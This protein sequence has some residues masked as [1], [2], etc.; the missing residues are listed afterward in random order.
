MQKLGCFFQ[1]CV[2]LR[3][4]I[5]RGCFSINRN[6]FKIFWWAFVYFDQSKL[7]FN[8]S[9]FWKNRIFWKKITWFLK[10]LLKALNIMNKMH[11]YKMKFFSKT[12]VLNPVFPKLRFSNILPLNSQIQNMFRTR[13]QNNYKLGWSDRDTHTI[14]CTM[15]SKE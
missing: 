7:I 11:E 10:K 15:F 13:T 5:D 1:Y 2:F 6:L 8:Q 3:I 4:S 12:Q 14:T 9:K